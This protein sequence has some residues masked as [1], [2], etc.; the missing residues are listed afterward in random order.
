[1]SGRINFISCVSWVKRG[2]PTPLPETLKLTNEDVQRVIDQT[3]NKL[4]ITE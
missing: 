4:N 2:A 3:K 1:M